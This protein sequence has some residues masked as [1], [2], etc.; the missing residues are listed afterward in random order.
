MDQ[1]NLKGTYAA[2]AIGKAFEIIEVLTD[3]PKGALAA[4]TGDGTSSLTAAPNQAFAR[5][6][7]LT[8]KIR[9]LTDRTW[10]G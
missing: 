5:R 6:S 10:K 8:S 4:P 1:K 3:Y 7:V 9:K 2:P